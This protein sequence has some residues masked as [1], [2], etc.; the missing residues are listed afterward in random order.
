MI[1]VKHFRKSIYIKKKSQIIDLLNCKFVV[2]LMKIIFL[3]FFLIGGGGV[4][5]SYNIE[6][7]HHSQNF[8]Q[9]QCYSLRNE[10]QNY[11][12]Y[13]YLYQTFSAF[14][15]QLS[16]TCKYI[17]IFIVNRKQYSAFYRVKTQALFTLEGQL[18]IHGCIVDPTWFGDSSASLAVEILC[19]A[20]LVIKTSTSIA[21]TS[22]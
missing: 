6:S 9:V 5:V 4:G 15:E 19:E 21:Y 12:K 11:Y 7:P 3:L 8:S 14:K 13:V 2:K 10:F 17:P 1:T 22:F 16:D 18:Y 20:L